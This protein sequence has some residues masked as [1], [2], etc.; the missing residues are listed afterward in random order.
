MRL[1]ARVKRL[2]RAYDAGDLGPSLVERWVWALEILGRANERAGRD[3][4]AAAIAAEV[5]RLKAYLDA[6]RYDPQVEDACRE[7][8]EALVAEWRGG[9]QGARG[10]CHEPGRR[11]PPGRRR[12]ARP[13]SSRATN[14]LK[15]LSR[16]MLYAA[17]ARSGLDRAPG[18]VGAEF[19]ARQVNTVR[20]RER[21]SPV[22]GKDSKVGH[23]QSLRRSRTG[24]VVIGVQMGFSRGLD[25]TAQ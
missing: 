10:P 21:G 15:G 24:R 13:C 14:C 16:R 4:R 8:W 18:R 19:S 9:R 6:G 20:H 25:T 17:S 2:E 22:W 11:K 3:D 1:A 5:G 12:V 23:R 7:R